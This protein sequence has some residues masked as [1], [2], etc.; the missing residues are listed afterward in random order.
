MKTRPSRRSRQG[1]FIPIPML[2]VL[3]IVAALGS[4]GVA[5]FLMGAGIQGILITAAVTVVIVLAVTR[6]PALLRWFNMVKKE[7]RKK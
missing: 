2:I 4:G 5:G 3:L 6:L 1:G 7:A